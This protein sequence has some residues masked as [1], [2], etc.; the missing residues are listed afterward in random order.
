M[1]VE[2][3]KNGYNFILS[4]FDYSYYTLTCN[5]LISDGNVI[6]DFV[7]NHSI[8][9]FNYKNNECV[10]R[11]SG[12]FKNFS[13]VSVSGSTYDELLSIRESFINIKNYER[14]LIVN[15]IAS[16]EI[17]L[18]L[19]KKLNYDNF[20]CKYDVNFSDEILELAISKCVNDKILSFPVPELKVKDVIVDAVL[21]NSI[22]PFK[23][24]LNETY[25]IKL[26][27][28]IDKIMNLHNEF[29]NAN[30][31]SYSFDEFMTNPNLF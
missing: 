27:D 14:D 16:G 29:W 15:S 8:I 5:V 19:T 4:G 18:I 13:G 12:S 25:S 21:G 31:V 22:F 9:D 28:Y 17:E 20:R 26:P 2:F 30:S 24:D 10:I 11:F 23:N 7:A 6:N 1:K 3:K